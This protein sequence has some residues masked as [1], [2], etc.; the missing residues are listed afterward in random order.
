[1]GDAGARELG[2]SEA[3]NPAAIWM[4]NQLCRKIFA[5]HENEACRILLHSIQ[6]WMN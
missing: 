1:L 2:S 6:H 5:P 4:D 3:E